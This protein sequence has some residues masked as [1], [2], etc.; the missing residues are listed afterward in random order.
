MRT[1]ENISRTCGGTARIGQERLN[2]GETSSDPC[3]DQPRKLEEFCKR[4]GGKQLERVSNTHLRCT[5]GFWM[6]LE[7]ADADLRPE[8]Q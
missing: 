5:C 3:Q 1:L 6:R 8:V 4:C 2:E 7:P